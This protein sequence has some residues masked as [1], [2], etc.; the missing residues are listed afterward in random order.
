MS[1]LQHVHHALA[2]LE[3]TYG[4][5]RVY[6]FCSGLHDAVIRGTTLRDDDNPHLPEEPGHP[7]YRLGAE[8][9]SKLRRVLEGSTPALGSQ[10]D[11]R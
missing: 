3:A 5:D 8:T 4:A 9:G 7:V 2:R 11:S 10:E 6:D 1:N